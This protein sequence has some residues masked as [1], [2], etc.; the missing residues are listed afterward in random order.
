MRNDVNVETS[1]GAGTERCYDNGIAAIDR[2][3]S[4]RLQQQ[5]PMET[6]ERSCNDDDDDQDAD[7]AMM[8]KV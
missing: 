2:C 8:R 1:T 5:Q 4:T 3:Q 6:L 7:D